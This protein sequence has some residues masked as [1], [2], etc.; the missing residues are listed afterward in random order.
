MQGILAKIILFEV[1][2]MKIYKSY[3]N[4]SNGKD[5]PIEFDFEII[6]KLKNINCLVGYK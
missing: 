1:N 5:D 4:M 3:M 6:D 2:E